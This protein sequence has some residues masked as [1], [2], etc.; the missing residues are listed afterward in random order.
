MGEPQEDL[1]RDA[2]LTLIELVIYA[3]LLIVVLGAVGS[4]VISATSAQTQVATIG[5]A[6]DSSQLVVR[7]V[8]AGI[9][10]SS[11]FK[12]EAPT[13]DGQLLRARVALSSSG[14]VWT[15]RAWYWSATTGGLYST[16]NPTAMVAAPLLGVAPSGWTLLA[17]GTAVPAGATQPFTSL[18]GNAQLK[19][20]LTVSA[21][22]AAQPVL[23]STTFMQYPQ[24]D[25]T[26]APVSCF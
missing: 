16:S 8:G 9:R 24:S 11:A 17:S 10:N 6:V 15:C 22:G 23:L 5:S 4:L 12:A 3:M 19:L 20:A 18:P 2:G 1:Q 13:A 26:S 7:S 21:P 25:L 14:L